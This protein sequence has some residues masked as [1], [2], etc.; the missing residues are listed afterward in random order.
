MVTYEGD[1][2]IEL[3]PELLRWELYCWT[4]EGSRLVTSWSYKN[5]FTFK[6]AKKIVEMIK[7]SIE[8]EPYRREWE[9][10][11]QVSS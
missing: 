1:Y 11:P 7:K 5:T 4:S 8:S 9:Y 3:N 6:E 10:E 2:Y